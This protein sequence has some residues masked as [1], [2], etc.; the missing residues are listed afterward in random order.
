[1]GNPLG[2]SLVLLGSG[3]VD[4]PCERMQ[5]TKA[6]AFWEFVDWAFVD[7]PACDEPPEPVDEGLPPHAAA[8]RTRAI[9][10][11]AARAV[12]GTVASIGIRFMPG[13]VR[14]GR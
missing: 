3:Y 8:S 13:V 5:W 10:A 9:M 14:P 1:L 7:P 2:V 11:A 12:A 6:S 4:T